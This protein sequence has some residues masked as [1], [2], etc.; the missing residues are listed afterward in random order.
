MNLG[1]LIVK[2]PIQLI[3]GVVGIGAVILAAIM[4]ALGY[5]APHL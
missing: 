5:M 2:I 3:I 1:H 4:F